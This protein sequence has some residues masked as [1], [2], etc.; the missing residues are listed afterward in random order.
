MQGK[1]IYEPKFF[2]SFNLADRIPENNFYRRLKEVLNLHYLYEETKVY[3]GSCGQK[4]LDPTVFFRLCLVG[5]L[6]NITTDRQL[7][8]HAFHSY[9]IAVILQ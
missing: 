5:Y 9:V 3:Y 8:Q 2:N 7:I 4:S 6:E 1:K